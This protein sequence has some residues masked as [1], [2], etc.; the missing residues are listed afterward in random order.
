MILAM[1][2]GLK[3]IGL[4]ALVQNVILPLEPVLRTNRHQS[5]KQIS[6]ILKQRGVETLVVGMVENEDGARRIL[7]FVNLLQ[8]KAEIILV[9][10][11]FTSLEAA[12]QLTHLKKKSRQSA[13]KDGRLD[14]L[15]ACRILERYLQSI[16]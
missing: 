11:D 14:S 6:E 1:D 2:V 12:S 7:H 13:R 15:A 10:E 5:A 4:A 16:S 3:R 8:T 9:N